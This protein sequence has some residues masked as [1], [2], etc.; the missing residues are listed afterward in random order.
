M[1]L[2]KTELTKKQVNDDEYIQLHK[3]WKCKIGI[4]NWCPVHNSKGMSICLD[5]NLLNTG[6]LKYVARVKKD[7][8]VL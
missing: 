2:P 6:Y 8:C 5:C 7:G 3:T 1:N 4:H